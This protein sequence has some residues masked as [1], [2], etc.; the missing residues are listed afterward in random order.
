MTDGLRSSGKPVFRFEE[1]AA[2]VVFIEGMSTDFGGGSHCF[3]EN[4]VKR[5]LV[6]QR[7]AIN[8]QGADAYRSKGGGGEVFIED[9]VGHNFRF[10]NETL[11]ARQFNVEGGGVHVSNEGGRQWIL[12]YKT[13]G[14]GTLHQTTRG[15]ITELLGGMAYSSG[16]G[17]TTP[18]FIVE[19]ARARFSFCDI[20]FGGGHFHTI[21]KETRDGQT[22]ILNDTDPDWQGNAALIRAEP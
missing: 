8:F 3:V 20:D 15:G 7:L 19:N 13:E 16:Q 9:V 1:G 4:H 12:G 14:G 2:P 17:L 21:L 5:T 18:M 6:L 10:S 22:R 11:W